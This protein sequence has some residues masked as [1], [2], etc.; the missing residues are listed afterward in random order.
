MAQL[1]EVHQEDAAVTLALNAVSLYS[2]TIKCITLKI[3]SSTLHPQAKD[4]LHFRLREL[5]NAVAAV[6]T[7]V[8]QQQLTAEQRRNEVPI[9]TYKN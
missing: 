7:S 8:E 1:R 5:D 4:T 3:T 2:H 6:Q 9:L